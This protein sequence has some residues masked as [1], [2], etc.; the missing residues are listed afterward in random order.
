MERIVS[1]KLDIQWGSNWWL[2]LGFHVDHTDPSITLHLPLVVICIG[3][4]KRPGFPYS[5]RRL[6]LHGRAGYRVTAETTARTGGRGTIEPHEYTQEAIV[7]VDAMPNEDYPLRILR[8]YR[9]NCNVKFAT[10][11]DGTSNSPLLDIMNDMNDQRAII[12]DRAIAKLI[13]TTEPQADAVRAVVEAAVAWWT[14]VDYE[15][16]TRDPDDLAAAE[17]GMYDFGVDEKWLLVCNA[18]YAYRAVTR[19][20]GVTG[21]V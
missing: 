21:E 7:H 9:E 2:S 19:G 15:A 5:L 16:V 12:L 20:E 8:A 13:A 3:N 17:P 4:C 1:R 10:S 11:T 18:V 6:W 14:A